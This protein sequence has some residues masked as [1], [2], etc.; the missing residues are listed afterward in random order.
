MVKK[1]NYINMKNY[2]FLTSEELKQ[3]EQSPIFKMIQ[4]IRFEEATFQQKINVMINFLKSEN[5]FEFQ[6]D[7]EQ[8]DLLQQQLQIMKDYC[9]NL[10]KQIELL[11]KK[12]AV[13]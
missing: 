1:R 12:Y 5:Y 8:Q 13:K 3:L 11:D 7:N 2:T 6:L 9:D 10:N 4:W